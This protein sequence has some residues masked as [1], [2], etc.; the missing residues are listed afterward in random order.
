MFEHFASGRLQLVVSGIR[1]ARHSW[2]D[3]K[4]PLAATARGVVALE[5]EADRRRLQRE[6][7]ERARVE[8]EHRRREQEAEA[9]RRRVAE[10]TVRRSA[11]EEERRRRY[12]LALERDLRGMARRWAVAGHVRAFLGAV[13]EAVPLGER[14]EGFVAWLR[15]ANDRATA[16]DPLASSVLPRI[17]SSGSRLS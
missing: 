2:S 7:E 14:H 8:A 5:S 10:G 13:E 12:Q 9:E 4:N 11:Q 1:G 15:W 3:G 6:A 16:L 17:R